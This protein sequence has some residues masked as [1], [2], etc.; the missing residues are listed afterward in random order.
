MFAVQPETLTIPIWPCMVGVQLKC[1][2]CIDGRTKPPS[3]TLF[4]GWKQSKL[5]KTNFCHQIYTFFFF[6]N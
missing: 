6:F 1:S 3:P 2:T 5:I 4:K